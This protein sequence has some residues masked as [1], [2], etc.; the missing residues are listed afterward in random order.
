VAQFNK[1]TAY[2][3]FG[4]LAIGAVVF[5]YT[6]PE[7][8]A[9]KSARLRA[10]TRSTAKADGSLITEEDL[11][12]RFPRYAPPTKDAFRPGVTTGKGTG[13]PKPV[14]RIA[15]LI[16]PPPP[17]KPAEGSLILD[18]W[19]LTGIS[20]I[21]GVQTALIENK[22]SGD[23]VF[24]KPGSLWKGLRVA[25]IGSGALVFIEPGGKTRRM[26]FPVPPE[27]KVIK[28]AT[29]PGDASA[30]ETPVPAPRTPR[31]ATVAGQPGPATE[32]G[33]QP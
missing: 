15:P 5:V 25:S 28:T 11:N 18:A 19:T 6:E 9:K 24:V 21:D 10:G 26:T 16:L 29:L 30:P 22:A 7:T 33:A 23:T 31:A 2:A 32:N 3:V 8:P 27:E 12:A 14:Q 13:K 1:K 17:L 4:L 20:V